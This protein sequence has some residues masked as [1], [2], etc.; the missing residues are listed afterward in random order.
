VR[1]V[2]WAPDLVTRLRRTAMLLSGAQYLEGGWFHPFQQTF[3]RLRFLLWH[4]L[5]NDLGVAGVLLVL[6]GVLT[7]ARTPGFRN[8]MLELWA[9]TVLLLVMAAAFPMVLT[10]F[11]L[12]G[13]WVL[14]AWL[15][16]GLARVERISRPIAWI[17][18]VLLIAS[19]LVRS[20]VDA[21]PAL[22]DR[23]SIAAAWA[24]WPETWDPFRHDASWE[25]Y[26]RGVL[27]ELPPHAELVVCWE[28][29][30]PLRYLQLAKGVRAD[31]TLHWSC[32]SAPRIEQILRDAAE[33]GTKV[34]ATIPISRL[35]RPYDWLPVQRWERGGLAR[36]AAP[37][38]I[39][40]RLLPH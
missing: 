32:D 21:P 28:E 13:F 11:F 16:C 10:S 12:A 1:Y 33:R 31:V 5:F 3:E 30:A 22:I 34:Y 20:R 8:R 17:A 14:C 9:G 26:A 18:L 29:G 38:P 27:A 25:E 2:E 35:P 36:N 37:P 6:F 23:P 7:T 40:R 24:A 4:L 39:W 19:P 15:G